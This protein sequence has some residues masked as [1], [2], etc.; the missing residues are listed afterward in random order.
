MLS[1]S[2]VLHIFSL[3]EVIS[4]ILT[5]FFFHI[6]SRGRNFFNKLLRVDHPMHLQLAYLQVLVTS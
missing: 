5:R 1:C 4:G 3:P 6:R 2:Y